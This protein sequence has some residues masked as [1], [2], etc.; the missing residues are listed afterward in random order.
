MLR[1]KQ[2]MVLQEASLTATQLLKYDWRIEIFLKKYKAKD[3]FEIKGNKSVVL[4]VNND[5]IKAIEAKD[6]KEI[7]KIGIQDTA[8]NQYSFGKL[9]KTK[10]FGG[11][12]VGFSTR[13]EDKELKS[14]ND[15]MDEIRVNIKSATVPIKVGRTIFNVA[16]AVTTPGTPKSDFHLVDSD[17]NEVVW[18]SHKK[19]R[20]SKDISQWGGISAKK[21]P[22]ISKHTETK[23]FI[24]ALKKMYPGGLPRATTLMRKIKNKNLKMKSVYGNQ[25]GNDLGRQNV[26]IL[27]QGT[28]KLVKKGKSFIL[29][30]SNIHLNGASLDNTE[31][32]P[33][34]MA[35][36]K[37][38]RSDA[39]VKGTR[40]VISALGGRK[41]TDTI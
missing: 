40:I 10:E 36:Y 33:V 25:Y 31:F 38:D 37:G 5:L 19:G 21:E 15:Q 26:S 35:I 2:H 8:G 39:G 11:K 16:A 13:D 27:L 12:G 41:I 17:G 9:E 24:T 30:S 6:V 34:F 32:E 7:N 1:F 20:T 22:D 3:S 29:D 23:S 18:V 4:D 14:L 28:V